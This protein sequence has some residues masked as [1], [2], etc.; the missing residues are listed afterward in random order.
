[1][2]Y[3]EKG[4]IFLD[5]GIVQTLSGPVIGAVIGYCTNYIAVKML[6]RPLRP[7][8]LFGKQLPFTPGIIPKGQARLARAAGQAVGSILLTQEDIREMLLSEQTK[9]KLREAL[10]AELD[11]HAET[12]IKD[13]GI[14]LAGEENYQKGSELIQDKLTEKVSDHVL[15]MGLG[16]IIAQKVIEAVSQKLAGSFLG[17]MI[18]EDMLEGLAK[19]IQE[20]VDAY[21]DTNIDVLL[22]PQMRSIW[23][24]SEQKPVGEVLA[25]MQEAQMHPV[26]LCM[27]LYE[28]MVEEKAESLIRMLNLRGVAENKILAMQPEEVETLVMSILKKELGAVVNLGAVVGFVIGLLNLL[29]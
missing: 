24:E 19:P 15:D 9:Q 13:I 3:K 21:L 23:E 26:D 6:F 18:R 25:L 1:M 5:L 8:K 12:S 14:K 7:V 16:D 28:R 22:T 2:L 10:T 20:H 4:R 27:K 17:K 11:K 29:F